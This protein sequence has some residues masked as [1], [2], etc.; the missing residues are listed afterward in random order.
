MIPTV[1]LERVSTPIGEM[2]LSQRGDEYAIRVGGIELMCSRNHVSEDEFGRLA[3]KP[4]RD[5][6]AP[7]VLVGGLGLGYTLR[8]ALDVL[9]PAARIDVAE[10]VPDVVRWNRTVYGALAKHPLA[11]PRV[12]VIED[13]VARVIGRAANPS[14]ERYDA[15][16]LDVD[17]GPD[18]VGQYNDALYRQTGVAMARAALSPNGLLAVWSSFDSATF[19]QWLHRATFYV[20][21]MRINAHGAKHFIWL[22]HMKSPHKRSRSSS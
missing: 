17:N 5:L 15:I 9:P 22:A 3:C 19:T 13:D 16:L 21:I 6:A 8:A 11:D 2:T 14:G 20:E 18:G 1:V 10:L 4:L 12:R 7:R